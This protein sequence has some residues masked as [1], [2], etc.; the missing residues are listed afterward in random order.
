M[1]L[2]PKDCAQ[3]LR[4]ARTTVALDAAGTF[5]G[6]IPGAG[7]ALVT[8]Q[9]AIGLA[10][11]TNSAYHGNVGGTMASTIG[12]AQLSAVAGA[13]SYAGFTRLAGALP[14]L[15]SAVS[16]YYFYNDA[17]TAVDKYQACK[18]GIGG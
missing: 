8:T 11:A 5:F 1:Q 13:A 4:D 18:A 14:V 3:I 10:G 17:T 15:G 6:A 12:G 2:K 9:V 16:A 7:A